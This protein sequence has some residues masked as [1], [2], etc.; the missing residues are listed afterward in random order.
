MLKIVMDTA[1]DLNPGWQQEYNID[2]I[3][4]NII[5]DGKS[6]QQGIDIQDDEFYRIIETEG[7]IPSTS[8]PTP[9]Q[10]KQ[11]YKRIAKPGDDILSIH[12]TDKLSGIMLSAQQAA[13]ELKGTYNIYPFDSESGSIG[14]GMLCKEA[15]VMERS[16]CSI[17]EILATLNEIR[18]TMGFVFTLDTLKFARL[19]GRVKD[20]QAIL[21]SLLDIKP[22]L[23]VQNGYIETV[24]KVRTRT[25]AI[26]TM[27]SRMKNKFGEQPVKVAIAHVH[28]QTSAENLL[29]QVRQTFNCVEVILTDVSITLAAHFGPGAIGLV[30]YPA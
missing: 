17:P 13:E 14:M 26:G 11:L 15:R 25:A 29:D 28:D 20:L 3:P 5:H 6:Y 24:A 16:G 2:L 1:G 21:A 27:L 9:Y 12:I 19:S 10:F 7:N 23:E 30:A 8:Q 18:K 4:I 22:I